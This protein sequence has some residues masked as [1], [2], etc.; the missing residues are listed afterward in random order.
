MGT[1]KGSFPKCA[2]RHFFGLGFTLDGLFGLGEVADASTS[3]LRAKYDLVHV[4]G[5][6]TASYIEVVIATDN[7]KIP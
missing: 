5:T 1:F 4:L 7:N 6:S 2:K 3:L